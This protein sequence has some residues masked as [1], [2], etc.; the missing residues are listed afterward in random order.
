[1][2]HRIPRL[3]VIADKEWLNLRSLADYSRRHPDAFELCGVIVPGG[4][5][6]RER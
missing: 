5:V 3:A 6:D 4:D 1:M 2:A